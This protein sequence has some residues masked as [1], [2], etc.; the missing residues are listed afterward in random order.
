MQGGWG[1]WVQGGWGLLRAR[2]LGNGL[3]SILESVTTDRFL[4][5]CRVARDILNHRVAA[6]TVSH[7]HFWQPGIS[8]R[9]GLQRTNIPRQFALEDPRPHP[10]GTHAHARTHTHTHNHTQPHTPARP[11]ASLQMD[12]FNQQHR[13]TMCSAQRRSGT[14]Q[15]HGAIKP[16]GL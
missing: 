3:K 12:H 10:Q 6:T 5:K 7:P 11:R 8:S 9:R 13:G 16:R 2:R 15:R 4:R 14:E 1:C